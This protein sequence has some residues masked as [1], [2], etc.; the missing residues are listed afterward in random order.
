M[1]ERDTA[2]LQRT[3]AADA[4]PSALSGAQRFLGAVPWHWL[5]PALLHAIGQLAV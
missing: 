5:I 2:H 3:G 1:F 4:M